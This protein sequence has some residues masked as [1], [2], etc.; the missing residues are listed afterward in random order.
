MGTLD[1]GAGG[2]A[3]LEGD[4]VEKGRWR[5]KTFGSEDGRSN[6]NLGRVGTT[7]EMKEREG[8]VRTT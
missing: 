4:G 5:S 2:R 3:G 1:E 8:G 7:P 6:W